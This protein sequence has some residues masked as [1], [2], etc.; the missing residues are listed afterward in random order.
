MN[1]EQI[2][3]FLRDLLP[4]LWQDAQEAFASVGRGV[5]TVDRFE[6]M[7]SPFETRY[8]TLDEIPDQLWAK[9]LI[10]AIKI[11]NPETQLV[12]MLPTEVASLL[13]EMALLL[14]GMPPRKSYEGTS[15]V[16]I[17]TPTGW[18]YTGDVDFN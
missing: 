8:I 4:T 15:Q 12:L 10:K 3:R 11:Y 7:S 9:S 13:Q 18:D 17:I 16:Y 5:F 2:D 14:P 1:K 6:G